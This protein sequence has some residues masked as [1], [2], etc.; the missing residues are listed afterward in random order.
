[1]IAN[2]EP[3]PSSARF[4]PLEED[5][6]AELLADA[7]AARCN[8]AALA[9]ILKGCPPEYKI[10]AYLFRSLLEMATAHLENTVQGVQLL[11]TQPGELRM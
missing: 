7:E 1:M 9:E 5:F 4:I 11:V 2:P 10:S 8:V 3:A 6:A